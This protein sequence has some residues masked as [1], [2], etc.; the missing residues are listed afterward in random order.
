M[1]SY[2]QDEEILLEV[3]EVLGVV[4]ADVFYHLIYAFHFFNGDFS[5]FDVITQQVGQCATEVF[6]TWI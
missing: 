1:P 6:V 3:E 4:I 2:N 5:V